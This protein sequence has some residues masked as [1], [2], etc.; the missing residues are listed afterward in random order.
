MRKFLI[1]SICFTAISLKAQQPMETEE[2]NL[3]HAKTLEIS[4]TYEYQTSEAGQE[5]ALPFG[6]AYGITNNLEFM[7][8]PVPYTKIISLNKAEQSALEILKQL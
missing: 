1:V 4:A 7:I 2:A 5:I 8:E 6:F 3:I